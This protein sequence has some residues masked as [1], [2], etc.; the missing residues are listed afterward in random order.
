MN[1][2]GTGEPTR[3]RRNSPVPCVSGGSWGATIWPSMPG[4]TC[5]PRS[6]QTGRW[7][8]ASWTTLPYLQPLLPPSDAR[9]VKS[10]NSLWSQQAAQRVTHE[11]FH[12]SLWPSRGAGAEAHNL[13]S[14]PRRGFHDKKRCG[15]RPARAAGFISY[16][17]RDMG[18]LLLLSIVFEGFRWGQH[19]QHKLLNLCAQLVTLLLPFVLETSVAMW[20]S[21]STGFKSREAGNQRYGTEME[22]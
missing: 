8:W 20:S 5:P 17:I 11:C 6:Y 18:K 14:R 12:A 19:R 10:K 15:H 7:K 2:P 13:G 1:C 9:K 16:H 3:V 4:V 21:Q 22:I